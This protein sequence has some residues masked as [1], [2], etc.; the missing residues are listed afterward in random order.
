MRQGEAVFAQ[1]NDGGDILQLSERAGICG[2]RIPSGPSG[3]HPYPYWPFGSFPPDRGN[4]PLAP[5]GSLFGAPCRGRC[6]HRPTQDTLIFR[7]S[8]ADSLLPLQ[9][10]LAVHTDPPKDFRFLRLPAAASQALRA[11]IP[12]PFGPSGHFPLIGGIGPWEG[13]LFC[14]VRTAGFLILAADGLRNAAFFCEVRNFFAY[15]L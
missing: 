12:T 3:Q 6:P 9:W 11:S 15:R 14:V 1:A 4:R 10:N 2:V 13:S 7:K 8:S 5:K